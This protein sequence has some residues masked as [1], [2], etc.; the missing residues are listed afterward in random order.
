V[1]QLVRWRICGR[2]IKQCSWFDVDR[3]SAAGSQQPRRKTFFIVVHVLRVSWT[4]HVSSVRHHQGDHEQEEHD[5]LWW[6]WRHWSPSED[7]P[8]QRRPPGREMSVSTT[9]SMSVRRP[10]GRDSHHQ[11]PRGAQTAH[12]RPPIRRFLLENCSNPLTPT[13][14]ML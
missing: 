7:C 6:G 12:L 9:R 14:A 8:R 5:R 11:Q 10:P 2:S 3:A 4:S 1:L 13:I